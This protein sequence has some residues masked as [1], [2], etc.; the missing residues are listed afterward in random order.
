[1]RLDLH[2]HTRHSP[3]SRVDPADLVRR[4]KA[5]G[6]DGIAITDHNS[7]AG[8]A[9]AM[10]AATD[11]HDFLVIPAMEVSTAEGHILA[12]GVTSPVPRDLPPPETVERIV[13]QGG[14]AVAAHPY[15]FWSGL[16]ER[17]TRS[18]PFAAYEVHNART[19]RIGN[20]RAS[21]LADAARVGRTGGSDSH[22]LEELGRGVTV[23]DGGGGSVDDA[24]QAVASRKTSGEGVHRGARA[25][26]VYV[27]KCLSEWTLR[28]MR[29]I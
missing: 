3:D 19:L 14:I 13:A 4:G 27:T 8:L 2:N 29:R 26:A 7:M 15:R 6:L 24:L 16:G 22:I 11:L 25:T 18:A 10:E 23:L 20:A 28:G 5:I 9:S 12:Y 1:M 21:R 17:A